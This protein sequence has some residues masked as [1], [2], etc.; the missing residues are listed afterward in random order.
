MNIITG[1]Y[2][3]KNSEGIYKSKI[4]L[5]LKKVSD[6]ELLIKVDNPTYLTIFDKTIVSIIKEDTM[7]GVACYKNIDGE[8]KL[9]SKYLKKQTPP[10]Y[11]AVNREH[12]LIF[13]ANYHTGMINLYSLSEDGQINILDSYTNQ[14]S[15]VKKEQD[16]SHFHYVNLTPDGKLITC[17]LGT[18]EII[19]FDISKKKLEVS[20]KIKVNPGF[21]P[22]HI[23]F[24]PNNKI[25]YCVGE[26]GS[27]VKVFTYGDSIREL[28][29]YPTIPES[30]ND[31]NGASAIKI[32]KDGKNLYIANRGYNSIIVFEILKDGSELREIQNISTEGDFPRDFALNDQE[33]L[34]FASNQ[35]TDNGIL[36]KI[37]KDGILNVIQKDIPLHEPTFVEFVD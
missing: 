33:K 31:H 10:A 26:L 17:D 36:Y 21:G 6:P 15:G 2:T 9:V 14:G 7:A 18:D 37:T 8:Y 20:T 16:S 13:D 28:D 19:L 3:K 5:D 23:V 4:D 24:N 25:F 11:V 30:Y 27:E 35:N 12:N 29:T 1:G 22:R 32:S 34:L